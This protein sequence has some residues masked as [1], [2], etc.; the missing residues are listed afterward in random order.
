MV[1]VVCRVLE[2]SAEAETAKS[3]MALAGR[4]AQDTQTSSPARIATHLKRTEGGLQ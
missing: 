3:S 4:L 2:D 1:Q